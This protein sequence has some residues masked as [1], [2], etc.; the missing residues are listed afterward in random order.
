MAKK[1]AIELRQFA[2]VATH[3]F[4]NVFNKRNMK[5]KLATLF[6]LTNDE[7]VTTAITCVLKRLRFWHTWKTVSKEK[8]GK[9]EKSSPVNLLDLTECWRRK[10][11]AEKS[12]HRSWNQIRVVI[13]FASHYILQYSRKILISDEQKKETLFCFVLLHESKTISSII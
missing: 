3:I 12:I 7:I 5:K 4:S 9:C 11:Q 2:L 13:S 8:V 10:S 6:Q 1:I